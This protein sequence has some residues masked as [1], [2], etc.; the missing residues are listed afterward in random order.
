VQL[1]FHTILTLSGGTR[2]EDLPR[3]AYRPDAIVDSVAD[4]ADLLEL[5]EERPLSLAVT[6]RDSQPPIGGRA[7]TTELRRQRV[8][9]S[10]HGTESGRERFPSVF[11]SFLGSLSAVLFLACSTLC[12]LSAFD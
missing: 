11:R 1:G 9:S 7:E 6:T 4:L 5:G 10:D 3:Y 8:E 2:S 12:S